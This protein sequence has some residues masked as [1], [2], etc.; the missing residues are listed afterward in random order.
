NDFT[1]YL[2]R[3][4]FPKNMV[5][6]AA[7]GATAAAIGDLST[8][9]FSGFSGLGD[10]RKK[11]IKI[12]QSVPRLKVIKKKTE[13]AHFCFGVPAYDLFNP[14]RYTL[15]VLAAVLGGGMSSRLF[16]EIREKR[17]LAYYVGTGTEIRT[18]SGYFVSRAGVKLEKTGEAI[19][20]IKEEMEKLAGKPV[21]EE[22]L[23][24]TKEM[25]KGHFILSLENSASVAEEMAGDLILENR[26]Y[27]PEEI[28]KDLDKVT[29][30][31]VLRVARDIFVSNKLNLTV[32][33][34]YKEEDFV[35]LLGL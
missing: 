35:G 6:A 14:D 18:E 19:K 20:V 12:E 7:G 11:A 13:Q 5:V 17:G 29:A 23:S 31:D 21:G 25:L 10:S 15:A 1:E 33:G 16:T 27:L 4:Y 30:K 2:S 9:Y 26:I 8:K 3:L 32:I 24:R 34:P 22:E 28:I